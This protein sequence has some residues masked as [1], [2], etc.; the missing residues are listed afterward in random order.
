MRWR[1]LPKTAAIFTSSFGVFVNEFD[2][3]LEG[4]TPDE[5]VRLLRGNNNTT[6]LNLKVGLSG[7]LTVRPR[8]STGEFR[9]LVG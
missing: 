8:P 5:I 1:F 9:R 6:P 3:S 7:Q 2:L 4:R